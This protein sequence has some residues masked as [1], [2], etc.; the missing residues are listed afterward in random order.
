MKGMLFIA[1]KEC[2]HG[3][4]SMFAYLLVALFSVSLALPCFWLEGA[5][6]VFITGLADISPLLA[7]FPL[8]LAVLVPALTMR[9]WSQ[10]HSQ[11]THELLATWPVTHAQV[12]L[13][14]FI[15]V[16][17]LTA[18]AL[19]A[20]LPL[21]LL[22]D[23]LGDLDW[24]PVMGAYAGALLLGVCCTAICVCLGLLHRDPVSVLL[25]CLMAL[26]C[27]M[28]VPSEMLNLHLRFA[29]IAR[30]L[31]DLRD[32]CFYL[33]LS[34]LFLS[35]AVRLWGARRGTAKQRFTQ[36]WGLL[37]PCGLAA[38]ALW[39]SAYLP[40]RWDLT[41]DKLYSLNPATI[42][43]LDE[44]PGE[45]EIQAFFSTDLPPK[46]RP[47]AEFV[48]SQLEAYRDHANGKIKLSFLDPDLDEEARGQAI[49]LGV[50]ETRANVYSGTNLQALNL[51]FGIALSYRNEHEVFASVQAIENL[52]YDLSA[53]LLRLTRARKAQLTFVGPTFSEG[54][55][56]VFDI[57]RDMASIYQTLLPLFAVDQVRL[58]PETQLDL[59]E[60]DVL[61]IWSLGHFSET[62]LYALDQYLLEGRPLL[63]LVSGV[64][65][66]PRMGLAQEVPFNHADDFYAHLGFSVNRDLVCDTSCT[67]IKYTDVRPPVLQPYPLFP[68]LS[69]DSGGLSRDHE[70]TANIKKLILPWAS[71]LTLKKDGPLFTQVIGRSSDQS[72]HQTDDFVILPSDV[73]GPT[74]FERYDLG[75][76]LHGKLPSYFKQPPEGAKGTQLTTATRPTTILVWASEHV[77]TQTRDSAVLAWITQTAAFLAQRN[78]L[79]GIDRRENAFRPI[80]TLTRPEQV[81]YRWLSL[82]PVPML[83]TL[84]AFGRGWRRRRASFAQFCGEEKRP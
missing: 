16:Y 57:Q 82:L 79:A 65:L 7:S 41:Q 63:L 60:T 42:K 13:G 59:A 11:G 50:A 22:V 67:K 32:I 6:N 62:Q 75:L 70:S 55:G 37:W 52:E 78:D 35:L 3:L 25:L 5:S 64:L 2:Q 24:G 71:S 18:V 53:A 84:L 14:K 39:G 74:S 45:V 77:L 28:L 10:E 27:A 8:Y 20:T 12:V 76:A 73:P 43:L 54:E 44:L 58:T 51:W 56:V 81:P 68:S 23:R 48:R 47:L 21:P 26:G 38:L 9:T 31:F 19:V 72:W 69:S 1:R 15:G 29:R 40:G 61:V 83:L 33:I 4:N 34:L 30:G 46:F 66:T 17:L 49:D 80:R 36:A